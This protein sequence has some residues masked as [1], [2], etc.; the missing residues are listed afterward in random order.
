MFSDSADLGVPHPREERTCE[1]GYHV[2]IVMERAITDHRAHPATKIENRRKAE[3]DSARAQ[4]DGHHPPADARDTA[5]DL[6]VP[7]MED[8]ISPR[9]GK[10]GESISKALHPTAF[11][12]DP[13]EQSAAVSV[14]EWHRTRHATARGC[15][16]C[17]KTV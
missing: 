17:A 9:C 4:L 12:I 2:G 14:R 11:V 6:R 13:D 15:D 1:R 8:P 10:S 16:S 3:I 5:R 7:T